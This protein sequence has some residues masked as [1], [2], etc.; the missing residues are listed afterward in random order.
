M[1]VPVLGFDVDVVPGVAVAEPGIAGVAARQ[2]DEGINKVAFKVELI[3]TGAQLGLLSR[4]R[5]LARRVRQRVRGVVGAPIIES[6]EWT[7]NEAALI[8]AWSDAGSDL[9]L[10][11]GGGSATRGRPPV[12]T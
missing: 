5:S 6:S 2:F 10:C 9:R 12:S 4:L 7:G 1:L 8:T 3:D 11:R